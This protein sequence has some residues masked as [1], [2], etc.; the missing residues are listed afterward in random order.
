MKHFFLISLSF[1]LF[2]SLFSQT[3]SWKLVWKDEF[4]YSGLPSSQKWNFD[5]A[6]NK[7]GWG[8]NEAQWYTYKNSKNA[9]VSNGTLKITAIK[10]DISGKK[11]SSARLYTK[12]KIYW[13]Y[14]RI[15]VKAKLPAGK[16]TWPAIW[17]LGKNIDS[18]GWPQCGEIDIMEHVGYMKDSIFGS[19]H[20]ETYNHVKGTQKTKGIFIDH[21]Y[22]QFHV[23]SIEWTPDEISFLLDGKVYYS[24]LNEH[25]TVKEW[26]FD[27]PFFLILNLAVGGNWGGMRGID[28]SVFPAT[29]EI[30]YVRIYQK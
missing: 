10:E 21:P 5:T 17:M 27:Q 8:N 4:N 1:I 11:Y 20:S 12:N 3:K 15:E 19:V 28:E 25:R 18:A 9:I 7:S 6:G 22:S 29:M 24:V 13:K 23:Y 16:G 30:D 14:G 2:Q 26:P